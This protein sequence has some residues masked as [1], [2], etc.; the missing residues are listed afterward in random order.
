[1]V[2]FHAKRLLSAKSLLSDEGIILIS[3]DDTEYANLKLLCDEIFSERNFMRTF[4]WKSR[5]V[6]DS[7]NRTHISN[8]HEYILAYSQNI[9]LASLLGKEVSKDKYSNPDN[10]PRGIWMSNSILGLANAE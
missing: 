3:I 9:D 7:R 8:D 10:D 1:M 2:V 6:V 4:I 5:Q